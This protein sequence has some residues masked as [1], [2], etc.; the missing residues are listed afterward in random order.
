MRPLVFQAIPNESKGIPL[1]LEPFNAAPF[2]SLQKDP[3]FT[4]IQENFPFFIKDLRFHYGGVSFRHYVPALQKR[5]EFT[6]INYHIREEFDAVKNYFINV[7]GS[8]KIEVHATIQL[9]N[10]EPKLI[11][12][13]SPQIDHINGILLQ[14]VRLEII[15]DIQTRLSKIESEKTFLTMEEFFEAVSEKKVALSSFYE[16]EQELAEDILKISTTRHYHH[17]RYL[18]SRHAY[19]IMRLRFILKPF[20]FLFLIEGQEHYH[21]VWETLDTEE[22]SYIWQV[23]KDISQ[24]KSLIEKIGGVITAIKA[25]GKLTYINRSEDKYRRVLHQY[26]RGIEGFIK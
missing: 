12:A 3:T 5:L 23:N 20:S 22:A 6:I 19:R 15:K 11:E 16:G 7:F 25:Q 26:N 13:R 2:M 17:L 24:L 10:G 9:H 21:M 8:R 14:A 4:T 1:N 18:S